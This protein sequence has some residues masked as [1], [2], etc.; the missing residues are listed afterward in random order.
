MFNALKKSWLTYFL[1]VYFVLIYA[2]YM[3][4][5]FTGSENNYLFNWSYGIIGLVASIYGVVIA[6]KKWGG[7][8]SSLGKL[9]IFLSIGLFSQWIGLQIWTYYNLVAKQEVPYPSFADI[10]YFGLVPAYIIAALL[11]AKVC[12][13]RFSLRSAKGKLLVFTLPIISLSVAFFLFVRDVGFQDTTPIK[14]FFDLAYPIGEII[15]PTI[16]LVVLILTTGIMGGK[17]R[18]R[19]QLIVIA[20]MFQFFTEYLFLYQSGTGTYVNGGISDLCY[21]TSYLIMGLTLASFSRI[22]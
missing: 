9:L 13:A 20:F 12:G 11:L 6:V 16:A 10:G 15:P 18:S 1:L 22:D 19:I 7:F 8:K 2:W 14:L 5:Q 3:V 4:I 21:A 17:M